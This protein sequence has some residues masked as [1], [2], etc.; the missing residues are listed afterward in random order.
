MGNLNLKC[1]GMV[2]NVFF[3]PVMDI[4][5]IAIGLEGEFKN[6]IPAGLTFL[7]EVGGIVPLNAPRVL[8]S[9]VDGKYRISLAP[10]V[11]N[12]E[13]IKIDNDITLKESVLGFQSRCFD[14][15]STVNKITSEILF[16]G[17]TIG[18]EFSPDADA[19]ELLENNFVKLET[20]QHLYDLGVKYT[21]VEDDKYYVNL[22]ISNMRDQQ[23]NPTTI[24]LQLDINDRYRFNVYNSSD[25]K[26]EN[27]KYS[28]G[29]VLQA[30]VSIC[31]DIIDNKIE[32]LLK[33]GV[34]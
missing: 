31:E 14:L 20:S 28:E 9:D 27:D 33:N 10:I 11:A 25:S 7:P 5:D 29:N 2:F 18:L 34:Y 32:N 19:V 12:I 26:N 23:L 15:Y 4:R 13:Q 1:T 22:T 6:I 3:E 17:I 16:C 21:F 24:S 30:L 8:G